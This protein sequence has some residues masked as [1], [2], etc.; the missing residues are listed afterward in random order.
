MKA[1]GGGKSI[2]RQQILLSELVTEL[3]CFNKIERGQVRTQKLP[4][5]ECS[6]MRQPKQ[7][8]LQLLIAKSTWL[9]TRYFM[10]Y[11]QE[12]DFAGD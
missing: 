8:V 11:S 9:R 5:S 12:T 2:N 10:P 1:D 6:E 7:V 4:H 3:V